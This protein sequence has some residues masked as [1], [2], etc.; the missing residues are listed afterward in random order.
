MSATCCQMS[1]N[2]VSFRHSSWHAMLPSRQHDWRNFANMLPTRHTMSV[3][4]GLGR[5][6]RLRHSLLRFQE[7]FLSV[8]K[9][10]FR[11]ELSSRLAFVP[12][13]VLPF[14]PQKS[15]DRRGLIRSLTIDNTVS[16]ENSS[17]APRRRLQE[18]LLSSYHKNP[19]YMPVP[20]QIWNH[21]KPN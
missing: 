9:A 7:S 11:Y 4:E 1:S 10:F 19:E 17:E 16:S 13:L 15:C 3:N 8:T 21:V 2:P 14:V 5:H 12:Q 18:S 6:D 20:Q